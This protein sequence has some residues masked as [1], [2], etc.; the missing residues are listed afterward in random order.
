MPFF[1]DYRMCSGVGHREVLTAAEAVICHAEILLA[2][3]VKIVITDQTGRMFS[4]EELTSG[5]PKVR[6]AKAARR[7]Q[8][9]PV[10]FGAKRMR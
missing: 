7:S 5:F 8:C 6:A 2:R 1:L 9:A 4:L 10:P 3:G